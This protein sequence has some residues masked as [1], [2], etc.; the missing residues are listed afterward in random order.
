MP[1]LIPAEY[2]VLRRAYRYESSVCG[3]YG[4]LARYKLKIPEDFP[5]SAHTI[6]SFRWDTLENNEVFVGCADI[7]ITGDNVAPPPDDADDAGSAVDDAAAAP[8]GVSSCTPE[9]LD[10]IATAPTESASCGDRIDWVIENRGKSE[11]D[12]CRQIA[13]DEFPVECG[14]C[15]PDA[16]ADDSTDDS[17]DDPVEDP[18]DDSTND[19]APPSST[20]GV[21]CSWTDTNDPRDSGR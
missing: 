11:L 17:T 8:C 7:K 18:A 14:G 2:L 9:V 5:A 16:P 15:D 20:D 21:C 3:D 12:A 13:V 6:M 10:T 1:R 4:T 19:P